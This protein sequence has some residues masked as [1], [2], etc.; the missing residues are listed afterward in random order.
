MFDSMTARC[1]G[2][3]AKLSHAA[4]FSFRDKRLSPDYKTTNSMTVCSLSKS[5]MSLNVTR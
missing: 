4:M 2:P 1:Q 3:V 5:V